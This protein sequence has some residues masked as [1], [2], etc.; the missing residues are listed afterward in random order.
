MF[1]KN[2]LPLLKL[3]GV[4]R[5]FWCG[6]Y[7]TGYKQFNFKKMKKVLLFLSAGAFILTSC[8][9]N[10]DGEKAETADSIEVSAVEGTSLNVVTDSSSLGWLGKKVSG[11]HNG[12]IAIKSGTLIVNGDQLVGGSFVIDMNSVNNKDMEGEYKTKLEDHLKS[13][14]FFDV[15]NH[16]EATFTITSVGQG[17]TTDVVIIS[18]NLEIRGV[19]KNIT[20]DAHVHELNENRAELHANF[21]IAREDWGVN[22][23]GA[24]DDLISKEINFDINLV[25]KN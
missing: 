13:A 17:A 5:S 9:S 14:D 3:Y 19:S 25:A 2:K 23:S 4:T 16:P 10:P 20:F 24:E 11:Q 8:V 6:F 22:Y 1:S 15:A 12:D 7:Y 18:G 21:N